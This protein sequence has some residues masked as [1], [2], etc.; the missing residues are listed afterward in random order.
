MFEAAGGS[1]EGAVWVV[2]FTVPPDVSASTAASCTEL[3]SACRLDSLT[4]RAKCTGTLAKERDGLAGAGMAAEVGDARSGD[5]A[6][7]AAMASRTRLLLLLLLDA[8][9]AGTA[10]RD[11]VVAD[12]E[13][14][15]DSDAC[16]GET[17][18]PAAL[19]GSNNEPMPDGTAAECECGMEKGERGA[20]WEPRFGEVAALK[21]PLLRGA[22]ADG[23]TMR[24]GEVAW[25][26]GL[27]LEPVWFCA[28]FAAAAVV[29]PLL[30]ACARSMAFQMLGVTNTSLSCA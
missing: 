12:D 18:G 6:E 28:L 15:G 24:S 20:A 30:A 7:E 10:S 13:D 4:C 23:I 21:L 26:P 22:V 3:C 29:L 9:P 8:L 16:E 25:L 11:C 17:S 14:R 1:R 2:S 27:L 19:G 5:G